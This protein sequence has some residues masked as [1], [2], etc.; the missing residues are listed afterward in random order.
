MA[1]IP[2]IAEINNLLDADTTAIAKTALGVLGA[3]TKGDIV[4]ADL[5]TGAVDLS[6]AKV[7]GTLPVAKGGTGTVSPAIVAGTN[8][9]VSGTWPNQ[10]ITAASGGTP[11][12]GSITTAMLASSTSTTTGVT[13]AKIAD[14]AVTS[15][16]L[17]APTLFLTTAPVNG[18]LRFLNTNNLRPEGT[19]IIAAPYLYYDVA[20]EYWITEGFLPYQTADAGWVITKS[21]ATSWS[22]EYHENFAPV[23][24]WTGVG[25]GENPASTTIV[26]TPVTPALGTPLFTTS[27]TSGSTVGKAGQVLHSTISNEVFRY[28]CINE[29]PYTWQ[30]DSTVTISPTTPTNPILGM[31]WFDQRSDQSIFYN[32][33]T[34]IGTKYDADIKKDGYTKALAAHMVQQ[35]DSRLNG[36]NA[37][38]DM[39]LFTGLSSSSAATTF[40]PN[41]ACW[42]NSLR[43]Q[44][45]GFHMQN[46]IYP[47][48]KALLPLGGRFFLGF[49]GVSGATPFSGSVSWPK[50]DGTTFT[51]TIERTFQDASPRFQNY[52]FICITA[53]AAPSTLSVIPIVKLDI[54]LDMMSI[55]NPP[56][57]CISQGG[58]GSGSGAVGNQLT[59]QNRKCAVMPFQGTSFYSEDES[60]LRYPF[61]HGITGGDMG[62]PKY[63]LINN[64]LYL[65]NL[66][67]YGLPL[68]VYNGFSYLQDLVNRAASAHSITPIKITTVTNPT[69]PLA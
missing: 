64:N 19:N 33:T 21:T 63:L 17:A 20:N 68:G 15:A 46:S 42:L 2:V 60:S 52:M 30:L 57:V 45:C 23:G 62:C 35:I 32:G 27:Q 26:W 66:Q 50:S 12:N 5:A 44:L 48:T 24:S 3:A 41:T 34:W 36:K 40:T 7:T 28:E 37:A 31:Q 39:S 58:V 54:N 38:T 4:A 49:S 14:G 25:A 22:I 51:T 18:K 55:L 29:F 69:L 13:T 16:K 43:S 10:T 11:A 65:Y 1:N 59:P 47:Q 67:F 56:I 53:E 8:I 9:T 61:G 6:T